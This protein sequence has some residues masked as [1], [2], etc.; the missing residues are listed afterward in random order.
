MSSVADSSSILKYNN[1]FVSLGIFSLQSDIYDRAEDKSLCRSKEWA[2][3]MYLPIC[4]F[5]IDIRS[6]CKRTKWNRLITAILVK[7]NNIITLFSSQNIQFRLP[8]YLCFWLSGIRQIRVILI[9]FFMMFV[10]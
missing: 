8:N 5:Y 6:G 9:L 3:L 4:C 10:Y 7:S 2:Y 1:Y